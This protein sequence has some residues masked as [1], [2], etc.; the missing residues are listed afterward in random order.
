MVVSEEETG[1][2]DRRRMREAFCEISVSP[3]SYQ[4]T[5]RNAGVR[6]LLGHWNPFVNPRYL[7]PEVN[8]QAWQGRRHYRCDFGDIGESRGTSLAGQWAR[9]SC[10]CARTRRAVDEAA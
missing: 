9:G 5:A 4:A 2:V 7:V 8:S 6:L 10:S 3:A 1:F